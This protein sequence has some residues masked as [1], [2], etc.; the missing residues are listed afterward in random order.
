MVTS[1]NDANQVLSL[2]VVNYKTNASSDVSL[3][4]TST[5]TDIGLQPVVAVGNKG[6]FLTT[7]TT[8]PVVTSNAHPPSSVIVIINA[9]LVG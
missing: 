3:N 4:P 8:N 7:D 2:V 5:L 6:T 1:T 9:V